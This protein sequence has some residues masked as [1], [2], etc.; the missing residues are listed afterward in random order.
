MYLVLLRIFEI[1]KTS[2]STAACYLI[3]YS[4]GRF[5]IEFLRGD[6]AR[7][8]IGIL[9]TSQFIALFTFAAGI[10]LFVTT[11]K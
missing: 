8:S 7:G 3:F 6:I 5:M 4:A 9:S 11:R 1:E 2:T 10:L